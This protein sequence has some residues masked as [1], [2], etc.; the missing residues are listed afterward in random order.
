MGVVYHANYLKF[1]ERARTE[2]VAEAGL[3]VM[4]WAERNIMFPIYSMNIVF[5]GPARLG[6]RLTVLSNAVQVSPFRLKFEQRIERDSD[7]KLLIEAS[8][9]VV[10]TDLS[11]NLRDLPELGLERVKSTG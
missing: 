10:C 2:Y 5:R 6:D 8:A 3:T 11:G 9:D 4:D 1:L 7:A